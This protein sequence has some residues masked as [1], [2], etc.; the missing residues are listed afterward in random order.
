MTSHWLYDTESNK[1]FVRPDENLPTPEIEYK[2][3]RKIDF[4]IEAEDYD[5]DGYN[6]EDCALAIDYEIKAGTNVKR[7]MCK[8]LLAGL[9]DA[10]NIRSIEIRQITASG[11]LLSSCIYTPP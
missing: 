5:A 7:R 8:T 6:G 10:A 2:K 3:I 1:Y 9:Y 11:L 4:S